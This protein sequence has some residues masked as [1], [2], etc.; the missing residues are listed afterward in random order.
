MKEVRD[1]L[2]A[3]L[4]RNKHRATLILTDKVHTLGSQNP[5]V[6]I[7][8]GSLG[9][10]QI[11]YDGL[12]FVVSSISGDVSINNLP[13]SPNDKLPGSCVIILGGPSLGSSRRYVTVDVA[14]PEAL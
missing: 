3:H 5:I 11:K 4:L 10:I 1:L 2:A 14:H 8:A 12:A 9:T 7:S 13:I 6:K